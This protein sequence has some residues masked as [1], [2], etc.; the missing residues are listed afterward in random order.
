MTA[1]K[2][3]RRFNYLAGETN[4]L[5][6][7]AA[8]KLRLSDSAMAVLYAL[9]NEGS[10]GISYMCRFT[11]LSKQTANSALRKLENEELVRLEALDGKQKLIVLT[12]K[13]NR[14][15]K[16]TVERLV[17]AENRVFSGWSEED[18]SEYLRLTEKYLVEFRQEVDKL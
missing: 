5:Y 2:E 15:V 18:R 4:N 17:E 8:L 7:E 14:F 1:T 10:C 13:G 11:G 3:L 6:H 12:A 16:K 9:C